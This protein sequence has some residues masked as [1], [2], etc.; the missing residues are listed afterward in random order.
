VSTSPQTQTPRILSIAG[1]DS[2][3][4]AGIQADIK[5]VSALGGY[6]AT[7]ITAITAQ[8]TQGVSGII[9]L[10]PEAVIKQA[11][12]V[13]E[14]IGADAIKTG[15]L[16]DTKLIES[17]G[18]FL[19]DHCSTLPKIIDPVMV[20]TS[21]DTLLPANAIDALKSVLVPNSIITPNA[22]EAYLLTGKEVGDISGQRRAAERL[23]E[24]GATAAIVK[25]LH[26]WNGMYICISYRM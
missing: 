11:R 24:M 14:D 8:N 15:M 26:P 6:A 18:Q 4:G 17:L 9:P 20:A 21:G 7:A 3:G 2:G 12:M 1:S 10:N 5:T 13:L 23:L 16:G 25:G 22:P 19:S